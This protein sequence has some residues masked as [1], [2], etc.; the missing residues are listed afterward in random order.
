MLVSCLASIGVL[1]LAPR[2]V[3]ALALPKTGLYGAR[4][5][6][7]SLILGCD[8][9]GRPACAPRPAR[10]AR[11]SWLGR[12]NTTTTRPGPEEGVTLF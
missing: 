6:D 1:D 10:F 11:F 2:S 7:T 12:G 4:M 3:Q 8:W 9:L 5:T